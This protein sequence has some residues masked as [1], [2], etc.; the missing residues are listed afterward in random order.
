MIHFLSPLLKPARYLDPGTGSIIIQLVLAALGGGLFFLLRAKWAEWFGKGK[1]K[2]KADDIEEDVDDAEKPSAKG[3]KLAKTKAQQKA[4][5]T[6]AKA[7]V[8][9]NQAAKGT[10]S[11]SSGKATTRNVKRIK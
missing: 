8:A 1:K 6:A 4:G 5:K 3:E 11:K 10:A 9:S 2:K 7:K